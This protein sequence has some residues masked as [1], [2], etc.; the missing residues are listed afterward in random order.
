VVT[1]ASKDGGELA[2]DVFGV[3]AQ[4][5]G[6]APPQR[7][8]RAAAAPVE[9]VLDPAVPADMPADGL[10]ASPACPA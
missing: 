1:I 7:A 2:G 10:A 6:G 3:S 9:L 4:Q 5:V 8:R